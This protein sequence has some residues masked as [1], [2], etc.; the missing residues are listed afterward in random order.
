[1]IGALGTGMASGFVT[2]Y[3]GFFV[4]CVAVGVIVGLELRRLRRKPP[5]QPRRVVAACGLIL[6]SIVALTAWVSWLFGLG[7]EEPGSFVWFELCGVACVV[8]AGVVAHRD[9]S[10]VRELRTAAILVGG[11][12]L[13]TGAL[14]L[15]QQ[16]VT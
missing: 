10:K 2:L 11:G 9:R 6:I 13:L 4:A 7:T 5:A 1:M 3:I 14:A 8:V 16:A 15:V 12:H